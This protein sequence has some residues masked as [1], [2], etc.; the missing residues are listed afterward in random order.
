MKKKY[1]FCGWATKNDLVCTDGTVI[2]KDAFKVQDGV[3]VPLVYNHNHD[4]IANVIGHG[5][6]ENRDEGVYIYGYLND[7]E[8]GKAAKEILSHGDIEGLSIWANN[9]SRAGSDILHGVIREV[10]LVLAGA[11]PG[12]F[13]ESTI[14]HGEPM[15]VY[16][17]DGIFYTNEKIYIAHASDEEEKKEKEEETPKKEEPKK[18]EDGDD[19][20][21]EEVMNTLN[22]KQKKAVAIVVRQ[23]IEDNKKEKK[24][25]DE[26]KHNLF[27]G[28]EPKRNY[29]S[30]SDIKKI[31]ADAKRLGTLSAAIEANMQEGG[32]L[33]HAA[34]DTTGMETAT[35]TQEYGINDISMFFP[36][37]KSLNVPPEFISRNMTWVD[38]IMSSVHRTPFKRVKSM[39]ADLTED[40]AR[41]K[42]YIKGNMKKEEVFTTLRRS[43]D[44]QTIYKKQKLD[45][46]DILDVEDSFDVVAWLKS[47]M[48]MMLNEEKARAILLGDGR[49]SDSED[50]IQEIHIRPVITDSPLFNTKVEVNVDAA[51]GQD[52]IAKKTIKAIIRSRKNYKGSGNPTFWTTEDVVTEMLLLEDNNGRRIYET[53]Q[54]LA[55][56]L[57]VKEIVTVEPMEGMK[58]KIGE[59]DL[60]LIGAIVNFADY[61]VGGD[62][63][64][65][66]KV[67]EGF[68][69]DYNQHKYLMETRLSGA[70][71]KPFSC[72]T[73]ALSVG[74]TAAA[75]T[76]SKTSQSE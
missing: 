48:E 10:S 68:D 31:F 65:D 74:G 18:K 14:S 8:R 45:R 24:E 20:T 59:K 19:E 6:L 55:T 49:P 17:T 53:E 9:L 26:V 1:D 75:R 71:I 41:A 12:A 43:T 16:D 7:T 21:V 72:L 15:D 44:P 69:I 63:E 2:R 60:P 64:K 39:Y 30:H 51:D 58:T 54:S 27:E 34:L 32:V 28:D 67:M 56:A 23:V 35:G 70:L 5:I 73:F 66:K 42:G 62:T 33:A 3:R 22:E 52:T 29:I 61:N 40:E 37:P 47:E 50:K 11:N 36:E 38:K 13:V 25:E 4:D 46:D 57:R 76:S